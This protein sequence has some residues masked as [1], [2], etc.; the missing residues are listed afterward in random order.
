MNDV[1]KI[2]VISTLIIG[3]TAMPVFATA[4]KRKADHV[5]HIA[6]QPRKFSTIPK[7]MGTWVTNS[8]DLRP[9]IRIAGSTGTGIKPK[10][11]SDAQNPPAGNNAN[12]PPAGGTWVIGNNVIHTPVNSKTDP[13]LPTTWKPYKGHPD[14]E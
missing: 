11:G 7:S 13:E 5:T 2:V 12:M 4:D 3:T 6:T 9:Q 1:M 8:D 10:N 14:W